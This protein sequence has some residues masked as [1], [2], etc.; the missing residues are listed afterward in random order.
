MQQKITE[1][2]KEKFSGT[3]SVYCSP[4]RVNLIG[5]HTD[6][7]NGF[8]LPAA[9]DKAIYVAI[10]PNGTQK[11]DLYSADYGKSVSF[12]LDD[13][14][15]E[16]LWASFVYGISKEL[17]NMGVNVGGFDAVFG[18]DV[19][20]G[21]GLSSS[22]ALE[23]AF[24]YALNHQFGGS[25]DRRQI[26]RAGQ[27]TEHNY[28]GVMCGIMDQ[29]ASLFGEKDTLIKLDCRS[30]EFEAVPLRT[31]G[32]RILLVDS[33][34]KH[35]LASSEYNV[36]RRQC[37]EGVA[38][39]AKHEPGVETLRDVTGT[40]LEKYGH[41]MDP[42][43]L[44]RCRFVLEENRR[45]EEGCEALKRGDMTTF[46]RNMNGSH[47][48]LSRQYEVSCPE[49]DFIADFAQNYEG[50][51]GARMMGGGFGGCVIHLI[52][53]GAHDS[54]RDAVQKAYKEKY[55]VEPRIIDVI[56][57]EGSRRLV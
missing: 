23:S 27:L 24:G 17:I 25:L 30:L 42:V 26:A 57:G 43:S 10:R 11:I 41:E 48:G 38:A 2:F 56:I 3:P 45:V 16:E 32:Y 5:D 50:V 52:E 21:A 31:D 49:L 39:I 14:K 18:G 7:N 37:E 28:I 47:F 22:A 1:L 8:V 36:R 34:V 4:G 29:F 53:E 12:T 6:Y 13:P 33:M 19:P 15:P 46:G 20:L 54:Y 55:A 35:S 51:L 40:M 44:K 9:I